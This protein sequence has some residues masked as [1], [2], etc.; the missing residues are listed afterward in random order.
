MAPIASHAPR[1]ASS[2]ASA[3]SQGMPAPDNRIPAARFDAVGAKIANL[4]PEPNTTTA[5]SVPWQNNFFLKDNVTW[6]DFHNFAARMD[7]TFGP[8][9]RIYGRYV[10]NNQVLHQNSNGMPGF[11]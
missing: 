11:G 9:E 5:G 10:W 4:Y 7:H 1:Q 8:K 3:S 6:Y 2:P